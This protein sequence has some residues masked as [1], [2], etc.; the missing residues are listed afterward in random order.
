MVRELRAAYDAYFE[1]VHGSRKDVVRF[2]VGKDTTPT[3]I[4]VRD[5]H[6]TEGRVI[7]KPSQLP[8]ND[9]LINGFWEIEVAEAGR[10]SIELRRF[11]DDAL[12]PI[13]ADQARLRVGAIEQTQTLKPEESSVTFEIDLAAGP[14]RLQTWLRDAASQKIRG[15]YFVEFTRIEPSDLSSRR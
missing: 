13:Q 5:W 11:P 1:D 12:A 14:H 15:A 4:T 3:L 7:W 6:P 8:D 2:I 10:Y 9:L